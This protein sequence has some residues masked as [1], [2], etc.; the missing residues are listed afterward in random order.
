MGSFLVSFFVVGVTG[1]SFSDFLEV[2]WA[3]DGWLRI[4]P[5]REIGCFW[6]G[7]NISDPL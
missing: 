2:S 6:G 3:D 1:I 7:S 4:V 5:R